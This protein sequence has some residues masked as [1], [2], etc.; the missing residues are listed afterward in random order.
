MFGMVTAYSLAGDAD[1][2]NDIE[3]VSFF[4]RKSLK[5]RNCVTDVQHVKMIFPDNRNGGKYS[6]DF[7]TEHREDFLDGH[8]NEKSDRRKI[9]KYENLRRLSTLVGRHRTVELV[10]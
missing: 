8:R 3:R 1:K 5:P 2:K 7:Q 4:F 9:G 6:V 10:L